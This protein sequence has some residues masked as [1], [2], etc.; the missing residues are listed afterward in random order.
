MPIDPN[1]VVINALVIKI[2]GGL[3]VG[4]FVIIAFFLVATFK[5]LDKFQ[6]KEYHEKD[7]SRLEKMVDELNMKLFFLVFIRRCRKLILLL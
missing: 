6:T 5:R 7:F 3:I 4:L 2:S 1:A